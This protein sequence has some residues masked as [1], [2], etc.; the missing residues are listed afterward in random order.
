MMRTRFA[1]L[2]AVLVLAAA[3]PLPAA[4][5]TPEENAAQLNQ[6]NAK[7]RIE[8]AQARAALA[9]QTHRA[10]GL[11][12]KLAEAAQQQAQSAAKA[13]A[14][15]VETARLQELLKKFEGSTDAEV[16]KAVKELVSELKA[17]DALS[18]V[19]AD[20]T[21]RLKGAS[22]EV[23]RLKTAWD[24]AQQGLAEKDARIK[25]LRQDLAIEK[26]MRIAPVSATAPV[27]P[28][29]STAP[30]EAPPK[31]VETPTPQPQPQLRNTLPAG[32][33]ILEVREDMASANVGSTDGVKDGMVLTIDRDGKF[34]ASLQVISVWESQS[35]GVIANKQLDP[36]PGDRVMHMS[37]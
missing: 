31:P 1:L 27:K 16:A 36:A 12:V 10:D 23:D 4:D 28:P 17:S 8:L 32:A 13:D 25:E 26:G 3:R 22:S 19:S 29:V 11:E 21:S 5:A 33:K 7:L 9:A 20:L 35:A 2:G 14:L 34:V 15:Q 6:D 24:L 37:K 18:K 30:M